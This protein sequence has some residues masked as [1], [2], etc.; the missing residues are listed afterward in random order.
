MPKPEIDI[1]DER[2]VRLAK[3]ASLTEAG[4]SSFPAHSEKQ[5]TVAEAIL[6]TEGSTVIT[7]GR[8]MSKREIGKLTFCRLQDVSGVIQ[9]IVKQDELEKEVYK[10]FVKLVDAGDVVDV[11][12]ERFQSKTG[13]DSIL[14]KKYSVL[15]KAL[16]PL[17]D[18]FHG[19]QNEELRMRKR[20]LDLLTN[21]E[22]S[23]SQ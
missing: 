6:S 21:P 1:N 3:L 2:T 11:T 10:Q 4:N 13:E 9:L 18:K 8:I 5:H 23:T 17:P 7:A 14:V 16:L 15:T 22:P 20:Y 19:L 12:G